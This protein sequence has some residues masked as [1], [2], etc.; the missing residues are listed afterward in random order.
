MT[1]RL[2]GKDVGAVHFETAIISNK[3]PQYPAALAQKAADAIWERK[4]FEVVAIRVQEIVQYTDYVVICSA[5]SDRHAIA[6]A[7]SVEEMLR[8]DYGE[9]PTS[10]E[11]RTY[12]RWVLLDYGDIV[13]HVFHKPVREYY[14]LERLFA[15]APR[16]GLVE[17]Q[18]VQEVSPDSLLQQAFDYGDE[19][20]ASAALSDR[21]VAES[22]AEAAAADLQAA[23]PDYADSETE[24]EQAS[25]L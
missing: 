10:I 3:S 22:V 21:D 5:T 8:R 11:G 6:V 9:K 15:D 17:P 20:W 18:W 19:L 7:D 4:G 1:D 23:E 13:V 14:Q 16:L 2:P 25:D 12:G 24:D